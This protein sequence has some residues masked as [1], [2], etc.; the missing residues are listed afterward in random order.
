MKKIFKFLIKIQLLWIVTTLQ[1]AFANSSE[2]AKPG[3]EMPKN[4]TSIKVGQTIFID[5][6]MG[7][8]LILLDENNH[9]I[10]DF[11]AQILCKSRTSH[12]FNIVM[13]PVLGNNLA[14]N[15]LAHGRK[16][17]IFNTNIQNQHNPKTT[18]YSLKNC[19]SI[20]RQINDFALKFNEVIE[21]SI[22][23][24]THTENLKTASRLSPSTQTQQYFHLH[25][26]IELDEIESDNSLRSRLQRLRE[27]YLQN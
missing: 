5:E 27:S 26:A 4:V 15:V 23:N 22:D 24:D 17:Y 10:K 16:T 21:F 19:L 18:N 25:T 7:L 14:Q 20:L 1:T 6:H 13:A 9:M 2:I 8:L 11:S 3:S 12:D